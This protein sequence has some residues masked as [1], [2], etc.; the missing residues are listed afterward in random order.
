MEDERTRLGNS[1]SMGNVSE[2]ME[3]V[4]KQ[5]RGCYTKCHT[6]FSDT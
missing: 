5:R 4:M 2:H 3:K 6:T 1:N